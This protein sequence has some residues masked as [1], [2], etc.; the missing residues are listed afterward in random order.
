MSAQTRLSIKRQKWH[1]IQPLAAIEHILYFIISVDTDMQNCA[2][3]SCKGQG[4][5][6]SYKDDVLPTVLPTGRTTASLGWPQ[7][8]R[9]SIEKFSL[10]V[11]NP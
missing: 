9:K 7:R 2:E 1:N 6:T 5:E 11:G 8:S 4:L 10:T 3:H